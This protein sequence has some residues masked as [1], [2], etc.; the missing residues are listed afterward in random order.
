[1]KFTWLSN[2]PWAQTGYGNQTRIFTPRLKALGHDPAVIAFYGHEGSP[3]QWNGMTVYPRGFHPYG[4]DVAA[5]HTIHYGAEVLISLVDAWVIQPDAIRDGVKWIP[6]YPVDMD[7]IPPLVAEKIARAYRR[8]TFSQYGVK[9]TEEAGLDCYYVPHGVETDVFSPGD[10]HEARKAL[11]W[12]QDIYVVGMVAANK[13]APARKAFEPQL[14]AFKEFHARHPETALYLHTAKNTAGE[15]GG[16]NLPELVDALGLTDAVLFCDQYSNLLGFNDDHM[17][18]LYR[19]MDVHMLVSMG[20]GFGIPILEAQSCG[21]PVIVG[22]WTAMSELCFSGIAIPQSK[23]DPFWTPLAAYQFQPR[24][25][26]I[27]SALEEEYKHPSSGEKARKGAL[28]YDADTVTEK[29]WRPALEEIEESVEAWNVPAE[30][31]AA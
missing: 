29:Y 3:I 28:A 12:P 6:W 14:R 19:A 8:I 20:E 23:A 21:T 10:K 18:N 30:A 2:A 11:G 31:V 4:N 17:V 25:G 16:I 24:W 13:G 7:P 9:K 27:W 15:T 26:P 1:M 22:D 5:A